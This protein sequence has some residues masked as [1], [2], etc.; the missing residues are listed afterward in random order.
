[1]YVTK[2]LLTSNEKS[3]KF[4]YNFDCIKRRFFNLSVCKQDLNLLS[5]NRL[6]LFILSLYF[7][8]CSVE[9]ICLIDRTHH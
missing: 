9:P 8:E 2:L 1:M 4:V 6:V 3:N 7:H 5:E